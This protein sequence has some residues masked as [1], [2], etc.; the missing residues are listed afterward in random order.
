MASGAKPEFLLLTQFVYIYV[1]FFIWKTVIARY[2]CI[3]GHNEIE[4]RILV[5]ATYSTDQK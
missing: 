1:N 4:Q 2:E 3:I 5:W